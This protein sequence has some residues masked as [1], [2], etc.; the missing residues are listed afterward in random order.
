M[1]PWYITSPGIFAIVLAA[2]AVV[3]VML[4][5]LYGI[6]DISKLIECFTLALCFAQFSSVTVGYLGNVEVNKLNKKQLENY[7]RTDRGDSLVLYY[8]P[9]SDYKYT[10][11]YDN[12]FHQEELLKLYGI[13]PETRVWYEYPPTK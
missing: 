5:S 1:L 10:M 6:P 13:D 11:P 12:E 8:L 2:V 4:I 3:A 7:A 9:N